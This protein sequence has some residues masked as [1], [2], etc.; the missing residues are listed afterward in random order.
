MIND[1]KIDDDTGT[2]DQEPP[3]IAMNKY[4]YAVPCRQD[5]R[6]GNSDIYAQIIGPNALSKEMLRLM[7]MMVPNLRRILMLPLTVR[8]HF[9][10]VWED[11]RHGYDDVDIYAQR[12][13]ANG[14]AIGASFEVWADTGETRQHFAAIAMD[15]KGTFI[16]CWQNNSY[17][18]GVCHQPFDRQAN[19][20]HIEDSMVTEVSGSYHDATVDMNEHGNFVICWVDDRSMDEVYAQRFDRSGTKLGGDSEVSTHPAQDR[21]TSNPAVVLQ[22]NGD[23]MICWNYLGDQNI[24]GQLYDKNGAAIREVVRV[25]ST[26]G[27]SEYHNQPAI[28]ATSNNGHSIVWETSRGGDWDIY[29]Q[30]F[31]SA[32]NPIGSNFGVSDP[33]RG[34]QNACIARDE[35]G[36][37]IIAW[38]DERNDNKD[39]YATASFPATR[40]NLTAGSAFLS[41]VPLSWDSIYATTGV[42]AYSIYRSIVSDGPY[43][44]LTSVNVADRGPLDTLMRDW[45]DT[46][47]TNEATF[48]YLVRTVALGWEGPFSKEARATPSSSGFVIHSSWARTLPTMDGQMTAGEWDEASGT[49]TANAL[50]PAAIALHVENGDAHLYLAIYDSNADD[51][52]LGT[53][54]RTLFDEEHNK[55]WDEASPSKEGAITIG[56]TTDYSLGYWGT[57][58]NS[59][60]VDNPVLADGIE[61]GGSDDLDHGQYEVAFDLTTSPINAAPGATIGFAIW[62]VAPGNF[63]AYQY[64][65]AAGWPAGAL[66]ES[67]ATLGDLALADN[68]DVQERHGS[69]ALPFALR[70]NY[71]N[72]FNSETVVEYQL[73]RALEVEIS[74]F[75]LQGQEVVTLTQDY[76]TTGYHKVKWDGIDEAGQPVA[77]SLYLSRLQ[78]GNFAQVNKLMLLPSKIIDTSAFGSAGTQIRSLTSAFRK[79]LHGYLWDKE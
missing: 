78:A 73:P 69:T 7:L 68:T 8:E 54:V 1:S 6:N 26:A 44:L 75:Y 19:R 2:E 67:A 9:V 48:Y 21:N 22:I 33:T 16:V 36:I 17:P 32:G 49:N 27:S 28:A 3:A 70:K 11:Y 62:I 61:K 76:Q 42:T 52:N 25:N 64:G 72:P 60:S 5:H 55:T 23:S 40:L 15:G 74:I 50:T 65:N 57:Y 29:R 31:D 35:R 43:T 12:F 45:I 14:Q 30:N 41:I 51:L 24:H 66:W 53:M 20:E 10:I 18:Y 79:T 38:Q 56:E 46:S 37:A 34:Q 71:P 59:I 77:S 47:L 58:P 4:G 13:E 39:I 63:Y